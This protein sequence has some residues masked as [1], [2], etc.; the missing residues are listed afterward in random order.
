MVL[1]APYRDLLTSFIGHPRRNRANFVLERKFR[2]SLGASG[3]SH[4]AVLRWG[5]IHYRLH[6]LGKL[7]GIIGGNQNPRAGRN[8][9]VQAQ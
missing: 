6:R 3:R 8:G 2:L 9:F 7:H 4:S 1:A 5:K